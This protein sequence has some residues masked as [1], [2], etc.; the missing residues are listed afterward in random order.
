MAHFCSRSHLLQ[1]PPTTFGYPAVSSRGFS[2]VVEILKCLLTHGESRHPGP[3]DDDVSHPGARFVWRILISVT[4]KCPRKSWSQHVF[5]NAGKPWK[6]QLLFWLTFLF[7]CH[8][9]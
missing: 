2:I 4:G 7:K 6:T 3:G 1:G 8:V 5:F 9:G